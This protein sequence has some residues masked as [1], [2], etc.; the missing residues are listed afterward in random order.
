MVAAAAGANGLQVDNQGGQNPFWQVT[1]LYARKNAQAQAPSL[2]LS[3]S[4]QSFSGPLDATGFLRGPRLV[5]RTSGG[6]GTPTADNPANFF[7]Q[8]GMQN[9]DGT[10]IIQN[11][12]AGFDLL[13]WRKYFRPWLR[14]PYQAY[15]FAQSASPQFTLFMQPEVRQQMCA[16]ENTDTRQQYTLSYVVNTQAAIGC[17]TTAAAGSVTVY[18]D[19]WAQPDVADLEGV[20]NERIPPGVNLQMKLRRLPFTLNNAGAS[21]DFLS[22]LTGNGIRGQLFIARD[23]NNVRQDYLAG[24]LQWFLDDRTLASVDPDVFFQWA[25]DAM[26]SYGQRSARPTGVYP[27]MRFFNPGAMYGQG[28]LYTSNATALRLDCNTLGTASNVPGT[29]L[30]LQEEIYNTGPVDTTLLDM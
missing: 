18:V 4:I 27:F 12:S 11:L 23:S 7:Y 20:E 29:V 1:N 8:A 16:L 25:Y 5:V 28:W 30:L 9:T 19:V 10:E 17:A 21:N 24:P 22:S 13:Q 6:V 14:D 15:D 3:G 26:A 2:T